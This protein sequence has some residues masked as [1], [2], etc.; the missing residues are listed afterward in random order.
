MKVPPLKIKRV[1]GIAVLY[2]LAFPCFGGE[3]F[4][5]I[6]SS[7]SAYVEHLEWQRTFQWNRKQA[8]KNYKKN[9]S[10]DQNQKK[11]QLQK[12]LRKKN[13]GNSAK[14][15]AL[16]KRKWEAKQRAYQNTRVKLTRDYI[17]KRNRYRKQKNSGNFSPKRSKYSREFALAPN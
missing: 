12:R 2:P 5:Q 15:Q 1:I 7:N 6:S 13:T 14:R 9:Y 10:H 8:F 17:Q 16:L 11:K 4:Q 3:Y